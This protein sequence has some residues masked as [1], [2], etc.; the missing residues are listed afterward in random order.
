MKYLLMILVG[1]M[2][3]ACSGAI[4]S[5]NSDAKSVRIVAIQPTNDCQ[6][7]GEVYGSQLQNKD[8][9]KLTK[10]Q[11]TEGAINDTKNKAKALGGDTV[12]FLNTENQITLNSSGNNIF[13]NNDQNSSEV[14][15][16][17][18]VYKCGI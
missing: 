17:G 6:Y 10:S 16:T 5:L 2:L 7:L 15:I 9:E 1:I 4:T 3:T 13:L 8:G 12:F 11:L 18:I 14:D